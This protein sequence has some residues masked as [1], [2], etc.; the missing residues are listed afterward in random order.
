MSSEGR[1]NPSLILTCCLA[2]NEAY[3]VRLEPE[4]SNR[5]LELNTSPSAPQD[6]LGKKLLWTLSESHQGP[7]GGICS[8]RIHGI[9]NVVLAL[10]AQAPPSPTPS[11]LSLM[12][13][14][15]YPG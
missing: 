10:Q 14:H 4:S 13:L 11:H 1:R 12:L 5:E 2:E 6:P 9:W 7:G 8:Y 15:K 3:I